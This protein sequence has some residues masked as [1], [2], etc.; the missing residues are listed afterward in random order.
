MYE[1][2]FVRP[3]I[4]MGD[5]VVPALTQF[6]PL[7]I[8]YSKSVIGDPPSFPGVKFTTSCSFPSS[9]EVIVGDNGAVIAIP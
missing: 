4:N 8:E 1:V 2:P 9:I 5:V 7:S 3:V 6:K